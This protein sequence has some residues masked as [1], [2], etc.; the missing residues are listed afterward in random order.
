MALVALEVLAPRPSNVLG[1]V[2]VPVRASDM[3]GLAVAPARL[4]QVE[5]VR[6]PV[7]PAADDSSTLEA[8]GW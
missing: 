7:L 2:V 3:P 1:L 8:I 5:W 6:G 4:E